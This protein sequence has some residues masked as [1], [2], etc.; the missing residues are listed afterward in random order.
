MTYFEFLQCVPVRNETASTKGTFLARLL[1]GYSYSRGR[2]LILHTNLMFDAMIDLDKASNKLWH[3][4]LTLAMFKLVKKCV[5]MT[6]NPE[7]L[8]FGSHVEL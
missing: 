6:L 4:W 1:F 8:R 7:V 3:T 5:F 2:P